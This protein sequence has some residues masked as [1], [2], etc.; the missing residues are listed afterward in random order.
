MSEDK[1]VRTAVFLTILCSIFVIGFSAGKRSGREG[2][3]LVSSVP[4]VSS[5][6]DVRDDNADSF[7]LDDSAVSA[8]SGSEFSDNEILIDL[9]TASV[10]QLTTV[11]GIGE[12]TASKI[13]EYRSK[14][15]KFESVDELIEVK[16]IG[17]KKL[18]VLRN[19]FTVE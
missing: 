11:P 5:E 8:V 12:A 10:E 4:S 15:G 7:V 9:N 17:E 3:V 6:T 18:E 1:V 2:V 13:V 16:G 14:I 19:Y